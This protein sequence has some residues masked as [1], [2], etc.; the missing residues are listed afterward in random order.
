MSASPRLCSSGRLLPCPHSRIY[1]YQAQHKGLSCWSRCY[2]CSPGPC[3]YGLYPSCRVLCRE[4][5]LVFHSSSGGKGSI[6]DVTV[7]LQFSEVTLGL[8]LFHRVT[9]NDPTVCV[10]LT[11][12]AVRSGQFNE[13][14]FTPVIRRLLLLLLNNVGKHF[15][16]LDWLR[17][18]L[19]LDYSIKVSDVVLRSPQTLSTSLGFFCLHGCNCM[20][21]PNPNSLGTIFQRFGTILQHT[22]VAPCRLCQWG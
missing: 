15:Q 7:G 4:L 11:V 19:F 8:F 16:A 2:Q 18:V 5:F 3:H 20:G 22:P 13:S 14:Q 21:L 1:G 6:A 9:D 12:S 17:N 10:S